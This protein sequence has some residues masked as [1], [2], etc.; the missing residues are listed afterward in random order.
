MEQWS[1]YQD[2]WHSLLLI[3]SCNKNWLFFSSLCFMSQPFFLFSWGSAS[4]PWLPS[5]L[6]SLLWWTKCH[7]YKSFCLNSSTVSVD[8]TLRS[9]TWSLRACRYWTSLLYGLW[10]YP[11]QLGVCRQWN[12]AMS[13]PSLTKAAELLP[14]NF[15]SFQPPALLLP[16]KDWMPYKCCLRGTNECIW[17][18]CWASFSLHHR[19]H[20]TE[21]FSFFSEGSCCI[22][23]ALLYTCKS[24]RSAFYMFAGDFT[25][26][27]GI[28]SVI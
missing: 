22:V 28:W 21:I 12:K 8:L 4:H 25:L 3:L 18:K 5:C 1:W 2:L 15:T 20:S 11:R 16:K 6:N 9:C 19:L 27:Y 26:H 7:L 24:M 13:S 14:S 17:A 23:S 10:P